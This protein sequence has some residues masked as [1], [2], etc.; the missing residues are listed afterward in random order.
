MS[1][2]RT[3]PSPKAGSNEKPRIR[4]VVPLMRFALGVG[5]FLVF[6]AGAQLFVLTERTDHWFAWTIAVPLTAAIL[7]A[8]Y[9]SA[10]PL[11]AL[12]ATRRAWADA[13]VGVPGVFVFLVLTLATTILHLD[14]F[15]LHDADRTARGAAWLWLGIYAADPVLLLIAWVQQSRTKGVDSP[16]TAPVPNSYLTG[17]GMQ[18]A[19][20][21]AVGA[22][23]FAFPG[24]A[25]HLW[26]WPLTPLTAR[27]VSAWLIGLAIVL[28]WSVRERDWRR[29]E[30]AT[31][32]YVILGVLQLVAIARYPDAVDWSRPVAWIYLTMLVAITATGV[33]GTAAARRINAAAKS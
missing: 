30:P 23:M 4:T 15:H 1:R 24:T 22:S 14:K 16:R 11:A 26:P 29:L 17:L 6:L 18:S 20:V 27:A 10:I 32:A 13:R 3:F 31:I 9:L 5:A 12:S 8:F 21:L 33:I 28:A 19:V 7:G 2:T 25:V